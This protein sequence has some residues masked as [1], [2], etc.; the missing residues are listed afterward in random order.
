[1]YED[2]LRVLVEAPEVAH[3]YEGL[4]TSL[5]VQGSQRPVK[6]VLITSTQPQ[7]G[8]TTV[9]A[10]LALT[11][12][13][14][15]RKTLLIDADLRKPR[16]HRILGL[17]NRRGFADVLGGGLGPQEVIEAVPLGATVSGAIRSLDAITS[18]RVSRGS[19]EALSSPKLRQILGYL[20]EI[21][22]AVLLD[23]P[24]VLAVSD[25]LLLAPVADGVLL[26][27]N[28]G[29]PEREVKRAV[30]RLSQAGGRML[31]VVINRFDERVDGPGFH[32]YTGYY[33]RAALAPG[34]AASHGWRGLIRG[35]A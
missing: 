8:K 3:A 12:A 18:G 28:A 34:P 9:A 35:R 20:Y 13:R 30:D 7:E 27:M 19:V 10:N 5:H 14:S 26:V 2:L 25:P 24:P 6:G 31:G 32:P 23:S 29:M 17:D 4:L 22:D 11:M 16:L 33:D 1:M 15:G 21:Y